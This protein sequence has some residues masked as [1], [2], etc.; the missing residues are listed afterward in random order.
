MVHLAGAEMEYS[1]IKVQTWYIWVVGTGSKRNE[2]LK[3]PR[4]RVT[5]KVMKCER[6]DSHFTS[7]FRGSGRVFTMCS[8]GQILLQ[9][10]Q[11]TFLHCLF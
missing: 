11:T 6:Q 5:V 3:M 4:G 2:A 9:N 10:L 8:G 7:S 1:P